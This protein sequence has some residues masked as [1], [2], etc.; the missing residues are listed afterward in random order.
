MMKSLASALVLAAVVCLPAFAEM[1]ADES[2]L[3]RAAMACRSREIRTPIPGNS[4]PR[5][6]GTY[7]QGFEACASIVSRWDILEPSI[8]ARETA[9][10]EAAGQAEKDR[11]DAAAL[12]AVK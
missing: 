10:A 6:T 5:G 3:S 1:S 2:N 4:M 8:T 12:G 9:T 7:P 11:K